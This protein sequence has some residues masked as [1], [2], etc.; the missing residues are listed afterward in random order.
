VKD[1]WNDEGSQLAIHE[2]AHM[3]YLA[4]SRNRKTRRTAGV[5]EED[6]GS[7]HANEGLV[8][9]ASS[10][11]HQ[12]F[13]PCKMVPCLNPQITLLNITPGEK[14]LHGIPS[15]LRAMWM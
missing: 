15:K 4:G 9:A 2:H 6:K 7:S 8:A 14:W 3:I 12:R 11:G 5:L 1:L 13:N 10:E